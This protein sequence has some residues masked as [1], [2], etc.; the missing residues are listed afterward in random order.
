MTTASSKSEPPGSAR[1]LTVA[2][3]L[4]CMDGFGKI[5][6]VEVLDARDDE[7]A[8]HLAYQ[9]R[10]DVACEVWDGDRL[11]AKIAPLSGPF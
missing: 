6:H 2:Y 1:T 3:R 4:Y 11:V 10:L 8:V 7:E 5:G 9:K